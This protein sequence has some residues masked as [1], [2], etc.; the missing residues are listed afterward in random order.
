MNRQSPR[1]FLV[2]LGVAVGIN[3]LLFAYIPHSSTE[4]PPAP[5]K[6]QHKCVRFCP[7]TLEQPSAQPEPLRQPAP[8]PQTAPVAPLMQK[9]APAPVSTQPTLALSIVPV[10]P[11]LAP[12]DTVRQPQSYPSQPAIFTPA[13]LDVQPQFGGQNPPRYP[14]QARRRG[15]NG[16]VKIEFDV[17]PDGT[18][19]RLRIL[20]S[21]PPGV[22]DQAVLTA[23]ESW[24]YHPGEVLGDRVRTRMVKKIVFNLEE[25]Q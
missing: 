9:I 2:G 18:V 3:L 24:Q 7:Q 5:V 23:A 22:F 20:E 4:P 25:Q 10:R 1:V 12:T 11:E 19:R 13:D 8:A 17:L 14:L 21:S 6:V 15:L 16:Y